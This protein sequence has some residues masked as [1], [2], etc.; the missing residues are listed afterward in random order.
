[1]AEARLVATTTTPP[2]E[3]GVMATRPAQL[4]IPANE[5]GS[6]LDIPPVASPS[7][8]GSDFSFEDLD[9]GRIPSEVLNKSN[10]QAMIERR[11]LLPSIE[12]EEGETEDNEHDVDNYVQT[13]QPAVLRMA[14]GSW[15]GFGAQRL[16][17]SSPLRERE[18]MEV[19]YD[20]KSRRAW[21]G[22]LISYLAD[23]LIQ[24]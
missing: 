10:E 17:E 7:D 18:A 24:A 3:D 22:M 16:F 4:T 11:E 5:Y 14:K 15:E 8:Y 1:M 19:E 21:S 6:S 2:P 23:L 20:E 9:E 12:F 13:H